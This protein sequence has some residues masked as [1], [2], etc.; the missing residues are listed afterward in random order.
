[1]GDL[2]PDL[3]HTL[4]TTSSSSRNTGFTP[5]SKVEEAPDLD[6]ALI[7][8]ESWRVLKKDGESCD[9]FKLDSLTNAVSDVQKWLQAWPRTGSLLFSHPNIYGSDRMPAI[10]QDAYTAC[11]TYFG[12]ELTAKPQ[13]WHI[14]ERNVSNLV[15]GSDPNT[16]VKSGPCCLV[17]HLARVQ[18]L[19]IYQTIRLFD[20][21]LQQRLAAEKHISLLEDWGH[22][23]VDC[24]QQSSSYV[25]SFPNSPEA[26]DTV[27]WQAWSLAESIRRTWVI[28]AVVQGTYKV[29]TRGDPQCP[30]HLKFTAQRGIWDAGSAKEWKE[31][32]KVDG[33]RLFETM[34]SNEWGFPAM[35]QAGDFDEFGVWAFK[36]ILGQETF[37]V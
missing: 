24:A 35:L 1:V 17:S 6:Q 14:I 27:A 12:C 21:D 34:A 16:S 20:G 33:L 4:D 3:K 32:Q 8:P 36:V 23:M 11:A 19:L 25:R 37:R 7:A 31:A 18:T 9:Y 29:M 13:L 28:C 22:Q 30:G 5:H 26:D 2:S 10:L 15:D